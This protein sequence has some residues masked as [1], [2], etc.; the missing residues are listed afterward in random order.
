MFAIAGL[1]SVIGMIIAGLIL[2]SASRLPDFTPK[3]YLD[4]IRGVTKEV[5]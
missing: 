4:M 1:D 2:I 3:P 5:R